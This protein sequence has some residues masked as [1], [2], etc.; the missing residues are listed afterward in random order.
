MG[1][2]GSVA[3]SVGARGSSHNLSAPDIHAVNGDEQVPAFRA[4]SDSGDDA[5][6]RGGVGRGGGG[7]GGGGGGGR[8]NGKGNALSRMPPPAP[9]RHCRM[10]S[11]DERRRRTESLGSWGGVLAGVGNMP[12]GG[13]G[14]GGLDGGS[15]YG[16]GHVDGGSGVGERDVDLPAG[17]SGGGVM[18]R[19][20]AAGRPSSASASA[21]AAPASSSSAAA[22][23]AA[24]AVGAASAVAKVAGERRALSRAASSGQNSVVDEGDS[25]LVEA[26][27][28]GGDEDDLIHM[29]DGVCQ[30]R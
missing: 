29:L 14:G 12:G 27:A 9:P 6:C 4:N 19:S 1:S 23:A 24:A 13:G 30:E 8:G 16:S 15:N 3:G 28:G 22:A 21:S 18:A 2:S 5:L 11:F 10:A 20:S 26:D 25:A 7:R 17:V